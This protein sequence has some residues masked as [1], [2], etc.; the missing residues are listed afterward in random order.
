M[1]DHELLVSKFFSDPDWAKVESLI[2]A[3]IAP[4]LTMA[5]VDVSQPAEHVKAEVIARVK[6]HD[7]LADFLEESR[8][9]SNPVKRAASQFR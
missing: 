1:T 6:A 9:V 7:A 5:D 4:L 3:R 8:L 2:L